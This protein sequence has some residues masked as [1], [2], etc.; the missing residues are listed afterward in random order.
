MTILPGLTYPFYRIVVIIVGLIVAVGLFLLMNKTRVGMLV[1]AGATHREMVRA[2]GVIYSAAFIRSYSD[3]AR[4]CPVSLESWPG[5]FCPVQV[6]MGEQILILGVCRRYHW[7]VGSVR[8]A[9]MARWS[10]AYSTRLRA[11]SCLLCCA[12]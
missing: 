2:L 3:L 11:L 6:G 1:R 5:L 10:P 4:C 12:T 7:W 8:G 9:F